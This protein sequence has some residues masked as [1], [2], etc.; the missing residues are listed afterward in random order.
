[1]HRIMENLDY[2]ARDHLWTYV[3]DDLS[4]ISFHTSSSRKFLLKFMRR[5][6]LFHGWTQPLRP[7]HV[8]TY[9]WISRTKFALN[10]GIP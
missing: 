10:D 5:D 4:P 8:L 9:T 7:S 3:V 2:E 6:V 1:M